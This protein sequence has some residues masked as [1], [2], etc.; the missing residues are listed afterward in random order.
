MRAQMEPKLD[1][2]DRN[3]VLGVSGGVAAYKSADLCRRLL[4]RGARVR[5]VMTRGAQAFIT[6]L[7]F[8]A[9]SGNPVHTQLLDEEAESG[10][11][12]IELARWADLILIAPTSANTMARIASGMADDLLSTVCLACDAPL[13]LAPAMNQQ[14]WAARATCENVD[15]L[16]ARG[17]LFAGP[18]FGEQ[19]CGDVGAGRMLEPLAIVDAVHKS[20]AQGEFSDI[21][22]LVTAGPTRE[23]IDPVRFISNHSSGKMGYAVANAAAR[24]GAKVTLVSGPGALP[25]PIGVDRVVVDSA[26]QMHSV[27]MQ[28]IDEQQIFIAAAAVADYRPVSSAPQKIKKSASSEQL[29][30]VRTRDILADVAALPDGPFT[31]G[32][33]AETENLQMYAKKKLTAKKLNMIAAN[34]VGI[35]GRGF[36]VDDNAVT[37]YWPDGSREF[38]I[39]SKEELAS[40]LMQLIAERYRAS[41]AT[42]DT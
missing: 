2:I 34:Q 6:P 16:A 27:V 12:H 40:G 41:C 39:Q 20:F 5:V 36:D 31:V 17:V 11:G 8:Q 4:E 33:A 15:R 18:G 10:M 13:M 3:I 29:E 23:A 28:N 38:E 26:E 24:M 1:T 25:A 21:S 35:S 32:F 37:V 42:Q 30:L 7:T 14:M 19:A 9:L 22:V